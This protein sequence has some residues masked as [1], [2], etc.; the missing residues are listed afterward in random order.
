MDRRQGDDCQRDDKASDEKV[1]RVARI[2]KPGWT[3][4]LHTE[5]DI[6][7]KYEVGVDEQSESELVSVRRSHFCFYEKI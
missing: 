3:T 7:V 5:T 4:A 2:I 1:N 6:V